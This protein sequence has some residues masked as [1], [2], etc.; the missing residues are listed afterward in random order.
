MALMESEVCVEELTKCC[1]EEQEKKNKPQEW[2]AANIKLTEKRNPTVD[3][4]RLVITNI[5]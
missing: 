2:K 1:P 5:Y 3:D 4:S